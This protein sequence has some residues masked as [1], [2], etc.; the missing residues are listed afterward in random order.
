[1]RGRQPVAAASIGQVYKGYLLTGEA[2]AI[3]VQRPR[4]KSTNTDALQKSTHTDGFTSTNVQIL[5]QRQWLSRF[6]H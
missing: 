2:V 4:V 1:M 5:T 6:M 3:K